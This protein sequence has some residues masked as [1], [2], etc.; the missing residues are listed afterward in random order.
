VSL[1]PT[2]IGDADIPD[3][4]VDVLLSISTLEHLTPE[5]V[6]EVCRHAR[7]V[8]RSDGVAV[9]TVDLYLDLAPFTHR[10][11]NEYG[12]NIDVRRL[13]YDAGLELT[14][15]EPSELLGFPSFVPEAIEANADHYL[16]GPWPAFAQCV[17]AR[18][19]ASH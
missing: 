19:R 15:G 18:P 11:S 9:I 1:R 14:A 17:V 2:T 8:I 5:D 4:S 13:L 12:R 6:A 3:A 7:R 16:R 10:H